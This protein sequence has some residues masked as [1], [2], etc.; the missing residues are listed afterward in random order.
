MNSF[1][2]SLRRGW[3][4]IR[5]NGLLAMFVR[6]GTS[7]RR[8]RTGSSM[9]LYSCEVSRTAA[10]SQFNLP[11]A[12]LQQ[13]GTASQLTFDDMRQI[14]ISG[15]PSV[16]TRMFK[17][18][19]ERG[20]KLWLLKL[21]GRIAGFGWTLIGCSME[22]HCLPLTPKDVH[23]FDFFVFPENRGRRVNPA[24]VCG[25]LE[26][27]QGSSLSRAY[28]E[29]AAWNKPQLSSLKH[30]PFQIIG[31]TPKFRF[32]T[33]TMILWNSPENSHVH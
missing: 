9:V 13:V 25:I 23:F 27:L 24:L 22:P 16:I 1:W 10:F 19:F 18:R 29:C 17:E 11:G 6:I 32:F 8:L 21:D 31:V 3:W 33:K 7:I 2:L 5:R 28:I 15:V 14:L 4:F 12:A 20:A 30:T 26:K